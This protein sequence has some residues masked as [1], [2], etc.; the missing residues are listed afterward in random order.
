[1]VR[2]RDDEKKSS[3]VCVCVCVG[4]AVIRKRGD[5]KCFSDHVDGRGDEKSFCGQV[6][7]VR[8]NLKSPAV[9]A[10][11]TVT[12]WTL[13]SHTEF[14]RRY[15]YSFQETFKCRA[16]TVTGLSLSNS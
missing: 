3:S 2:K 4:G 14:V 12:I 13:K 5:E 8:Y 11:V 9:A 10:F 7:F 16:P 6:K 15:I 1:M